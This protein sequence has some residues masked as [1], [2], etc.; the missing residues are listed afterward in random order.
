M[1][2]GL[3]RNLL[4][5]HLKSLHHIFHDF[6][7]EHAFDIYAEPRVPRYY[8]HTYLKIVV[9][10]AEVGRHVVLVEKRKQ[11]VDEAFGWSVLTDTEDW[12]MAG[13]YQVFGTKN[14]TSEYCRTQQ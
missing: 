10:T 9:M 8:L 1:I 4:N 2:K 5:C 7:N 14:D 13:Y 11:L 6:P 3:Q 12:I